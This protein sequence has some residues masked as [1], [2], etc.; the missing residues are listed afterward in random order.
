MRPNFL[1]LAAVSSF[2]LATPAL[3][4]PGDPILLGDGVT[5]DPILDANLRYESVSQAGIANDADAVTLRLR[6]GAELKASGFA[7]LAE[8]E[9]TAALDDHYNDTL[10]GNGIEPY[11]VV[12]DPAN[13]ELNRLQTVL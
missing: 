2:G 13:F 9:G 3:A 4:A 12:A 10:P 8:G 1:L 6:L 11:P 7:F 5:L